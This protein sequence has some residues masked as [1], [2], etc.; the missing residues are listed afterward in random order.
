MPSLP[1]GRT[2]RKWI[3]T[4]LSVVSVDYTVSPRII[5]IASPTAEVSIQDMYD[6]LRVI[7]ARVQNIAFPSLVSAGGKEDLGGGTSVGITMT[8]QNA[9]ISWGDRGSPTRA[10]IAGGNIVAI[11]SAGVPLAVDVFST[12]IN[13]VIA[14]SS[15]AT[16][17]DQQL[18]SATKYLV[19]SKL[20]CHPNLGDQFY[21]DPI[22]GDDLNEGIL[23]SSAKKT[24]AGAFALCVAGHYDAIYIV[25]DNAPSS[26]IIIT[27]RIVIN[28]ANVM[29]RGPGRGATIAPTDDSADTII[30]DGAIGVEIDCFTVNTGPGPTARN[31]ISVINGADFAK[32]SSIWIDSCTGNGLNIT[33][34]DHHLI[35]TVFIDGPVGHGIL[36]D[37]TIA[38]EITT[39]RIFNAGGDAIRILSTGGSGSTQHVISKDNLSQNNVGD[40]HFIG[41]GAL[42]TTLRFVNEIGDNVTDNGTDTKI[43]RDE[44]ID[45]VWNEAQADHIASGSL[46]ASVL[47][48]KYQDGI[49]V[50][51]NNGT[52]G[53][54]IGTNGTPD[55]P[56]V[57][58]ADARTLANALGFRTYY[59]IDGFFQLEENHDNW[60]IIAVDEFSDTVGNKASMVFNGFTF[61]N[62]TMRGVAVFDISGAGSSDILRNVTFIRCSFP[63]AHSTAAEYQS[64]VF[65]DCIIVDDLDVASCDFHNC[66]FQDGTSIVE[67]TGTG[68]AGNLGNRFISCSGAL[69]VN[70]FTLRFSD[71]WRFDDWSGRLILGSSLLPGTSSGGAFRVSGI[72]ELNNNS[73]LGVRLDHDG[74][75]TSTVSAEGAVSTGATST[76]VLTT[77][78]GF[79]DDFFNDMQVVIFA[80]GG[81]GVARNVND[82]VSSTGAFHVGALPFTPFAGT[83]VQVVRRT[84]LAAAS[85]I[86]NAV[87]DEA[88]SA[89]TSAGTFGE[90][91]K[92]LFDT[93]PILQGLSHDNSVLDQQVYDSND[94]PR[95]LSAR[96]R[97]YSTRAAAEAAGASGL[98]NTYIITATYD[99]SGNQTTYTL[100]RVGS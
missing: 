62:S 27:E 90:V 87:W 97:S 35:S 82:Y 36:V 41:T 60:R 6:T 86:A 10:K 24:F 25:T 84:G 67:N 77:I 19:E 92:N 45:L 44:L 61:L 69:L 33:G 7:E 93:L 96:L 76:V 31:A 65:N 15:N 56:V 73:P 48:A 58:L 5:S 4:F 9:Q 47:V 46:G 78:T 57:G 79:G 85:S 89:H 72:G 3:V 42:T 16:L 53:T 20:P 34:G 74:F 37:N 28:K 99:G 2:V 39:C 70:S 91:M 63:G 14:Q 29:L 59:I 54:T 52:A 21:W 8:L 43:E 75:V 30:I 98:V 94:P 13:S 68:G 50:N 51:G 64:C 12:N 81:R 17:L 66:Q 40:G 18:S 80:L 88:R 26:G 1:Y 55:N 23:P 71:R 11:D 100:V 95:L 32:I 38:T 49:W 22:A 83:V